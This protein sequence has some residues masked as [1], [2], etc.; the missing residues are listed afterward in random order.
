MTCQ[1]LS[2]WVDRD[3]PIGIASDH[4]GFDLKEK[5]RE[6]LQKLG[7]QVRDF[8]TY[9]RKRTD[10]PDFGS[11]CARAV[12][13]GECTA[14]ILVCGTGIGMSIV[15]NKVK[16]VRAALCDSVTTARLSRQHNDA[17]ILTLGGRII[18]VSV[19]FDIVDTWLSTD[20]EGGR[21]ARRVEKIIELDRADP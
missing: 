11:E 8:G 6:H 15:A 3:K 16:G 13:K 2:T 1:T 10:Y 4:A 5:I 14:G 21:H 19:A 9:D 20:F 18:G 12:A 7:F 17:N